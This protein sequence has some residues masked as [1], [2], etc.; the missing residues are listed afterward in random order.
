[1]YIYRHHTSNLDWAKEKVP[2]KVE[3]MCKCFQRHN[4]Y[5]KTKNYS[6]YTL[7]IHPVFW[8][9]IKKICDTHN[10]LYIQVTILMK[11]K[12]NDWWL[13]TMNTCKIFWYF[14]RKF[15]SKYSCEFPLSPQSR[16]YD[17][18]LPIQTNYEFIMFL[19]T[20]NKKYCVLFSLHT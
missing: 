3:R 12:F 13:K 14:S 1:M 6:L 8:I 9:L 17:P 10:I 20:N 7:F 5:I 15:L 4:E 16:S 18:G 19:P 2:P 11:N